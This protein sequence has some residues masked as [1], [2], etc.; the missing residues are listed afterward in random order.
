MAVRKGHETVAFQ[1]VKDTLAQ[2]V[3]DDADVALIVEAVRQVYASVSVFG[4]V[5]FESSQ[6][7]QFNPRCVAIFLHRSDDFDRH[8]FVTLTITRLDYLTKGSLT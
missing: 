8:S 5:G 1:K 7:S 3:H 4:I 6:D 2:E